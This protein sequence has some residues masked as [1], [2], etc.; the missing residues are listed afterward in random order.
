MKMVYKKKI[1]KNIFQIIV[2]FLLFLLH[3]ITFFFWSFYF[4]A[5]AN[6]LI[7]FYKILSY[8]LEW[9]VI[10]LLAILLAGLFS[11]LAIRMHKKI[12]KKW[13]F[14]IV[15]AIISL[16]FLLLTLHLIGQIVIV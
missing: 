11:L 3:L 5:V 14:L 9:T 6:E 12:T 8:N 15:Y 1:I 7:P 2:F 13:I 4:Y 16:V 10:L